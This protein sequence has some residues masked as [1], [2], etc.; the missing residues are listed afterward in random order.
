MEAALELLATANSRK[1]AILGDMFELGENE[2]ALHRRVGAFAANKAIDLILCVGTLSQ[3]MYEEAIA[4]GA[5]AK[6]Y[7]TKEV[8][9]EELPKLLK[10]GDT[11]LLKASHGMGFSSMIDTMKELQLQ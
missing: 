6:Y 8:L 5:Q 3:S 7:N 4:Q 11:I 10:K 1:V 9:L 2:L